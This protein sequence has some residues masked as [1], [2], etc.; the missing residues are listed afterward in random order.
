MNKKFLTAAVAAAVAVVVLVG[1]YF[2][3]ARY[4]SNAARTHV[5]A[6]ITKTGPAANVV[7]KDVSYNLFTRQTVISD[8]SILP[9][10]GVAPIRIKEVV[11]RSIDEATP[12]PTFL[13]LDIRGIQL[14]PATFGVTEAA[15]FVA[16]GYVG[17]M[18]CDL[19]ID[20]AYAKDKR[21]LSLNAISLSIKDAATIRLSLT[22]GN[23]DFDPTQ[24]ATLLF[25][26]PRILLQQ[27]ELVYT[28]ASL[29]ERVLK[30]EAAKKRI[31]V[32][33]LK[34]SLAVDADAALRRDQSPLSAAIL[35]ALKQFIENPRQLSISVTP[36]KPI[37]LGEIGRGGS[38]EAVAKLL[39]LQV[40]S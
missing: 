16:L 22:L 25:T 12:I 1:A 14:D 26:Y 18:V 6:A 30:E 9:P 8:V 10:G 2:G 24:A 38:P 34:K 3:L 20:Y 28:D 23:M 36:A 31:D 4:A 40:K 5:D 19:G 11:V 27:A 29:L 33:S 15:R 32:A 17:P 7:Y 35:T 37:P 13:A 39:N 21:V